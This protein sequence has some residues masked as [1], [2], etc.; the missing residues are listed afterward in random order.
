MTDESK[1]TIRFYTDTHIARAVAAQLRLRGV[2][3]LRCE[4]VG[5]AEVS[6]QE[7]MAYAAQNS[8][9]IVTHDQGHMLDRVEERRI[10]WYG[11]GKS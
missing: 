1:P 3:V 10:S 7:H 11:L 9:A 6:D 8:L 4:D 5:L 2:E